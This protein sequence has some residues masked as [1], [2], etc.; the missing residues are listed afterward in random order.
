VAGENPWKVS[1]YLKNILKG[2]G[3]P[4]KG[5]PRRV[6]R[7]NAHIKIFFLRAEK[8]E[9]MSTPILRRISKVRRG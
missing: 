4:E 5:D 3:E 2:Q 9:P 1:L 6:T 8:S 7:V